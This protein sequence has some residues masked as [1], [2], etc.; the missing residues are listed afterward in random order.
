[1]PRANR[2]N[3][4]QKLAVVALGAATLAITGAAQLPAHADYGPTIPLQP[5]PGGYT[6]VVASTTIGSAGGTI[7]PVAVDG[8]S[9][10]LRVR[11]GTFTT[12]VQVTITAPSASGVGDAGHP[13]DRA[14]CG[15]GVLVQVNG[16]VY[17]G[18]FGH[19]LTLTITGS[20]IKAGDRVAVWNGQAFV[21]A[22]ATV[23]GDTARVRAVGSSD[24]FAVLA[25]G[26]GRSES[27]PGGATVAAR[28]SQGTRAAEAVLTRLF[29][30]PASLS[31][32]GIGVLAPEWLDI[33]SR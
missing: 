27:P 5:V 15:V 31:L 30:A 14:V 29:L 9:A 26:G 10:F 16:T 22:S 1:M 24:A 13:G 19:S 32:A 28:S 21:F 33:I 3:L 4:A 23:A 6:S 2:S 8:C 12:P 18:N 11:P 20:S 25:P 7:G 17:T